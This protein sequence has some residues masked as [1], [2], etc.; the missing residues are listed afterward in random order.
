MSIAGRVNTPDPGD[1][2]SLGVVL[3]LGGEWPGL[4]A[5]LEVESTYAWPMLDVDR[6]ELFDFAEQY[7]VTALFNAAVGIFAV[8]L[9]KFGI[10][11]ALPPPG[12]VVDI[13]SQFIDQARELV[14]RNGTDTGT[15]GDGPADQSRSVLG[16]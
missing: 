4:E 2:A 13:A 6:D 10:R 9:R 1:S 12:L 14:G 8:E 15:A 7:A 3:R 16:E 11:I 5:S